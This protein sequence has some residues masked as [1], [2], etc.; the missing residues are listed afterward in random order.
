MTVS[1]W[2]T[3]YS[4]DTCN[5]YSAGF[6]TT[7]HHLKYTMSAAEYLPDRPVYSL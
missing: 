4:C 5:N 7:D 2:R 1:E 6:R 3:D